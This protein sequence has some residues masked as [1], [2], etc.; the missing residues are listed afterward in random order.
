ML[1]N[2]IPSK[3]ELAKLSSNIG[4]VSVVENDN[5]VSETLSSQLIT[6]YLGTVTIT[7]NI[8]E[9][10]SVTGQASTSALGSPTVSAD[11]VYTVTVA[12]GTNSY[13]SGNNC[14][15]YT[16]P[17]PRDLSTSRMPSSA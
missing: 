8:S 4:S 15:L 13:G 7:G 5:T 1:P 6:A 17:S 2:T 9:S 11:T 14:L 10:V 16:S 3:F 12:S